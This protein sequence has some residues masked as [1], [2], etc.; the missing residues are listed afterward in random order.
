MPSPWR[1]GSAESLRH[2]RPNTAE[3]GDSYELII[4]DSYQFSPPPA[5]RPH[6]RRRRKIVA[7][8]NFRRKIVA[9]P[10]LTEPA[11]HARENRLVRHSPAGKQRHPEPAAA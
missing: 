9:V 4:G 10:N 1:P 6:P 11:D 5:S 7:V 8:P 2:L 3:I